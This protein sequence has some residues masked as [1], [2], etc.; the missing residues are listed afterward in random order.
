MYELV[1]KNQDGIFSK[2]TSDDLNRLKVVAKRLNSNGCD[3][4]IIEKRVVFRIVNVED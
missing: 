2:I 3:V 4:E 1:I